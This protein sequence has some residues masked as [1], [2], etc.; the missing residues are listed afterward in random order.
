[1][2]RKIDV[3]KQM[4]ATK[5]NAAKR[6]PERCMLLAEPTSRL[7]C[8]LRRAS[9]QTPWLIHDAGFMRTGTFAVTQMRLHLVHENA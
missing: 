2:R 4:L 1:M 3:T 7:G 5:N 9:M 8:G 6:L